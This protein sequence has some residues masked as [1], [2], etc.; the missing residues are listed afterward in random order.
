M[1]TPTRPQRLYLLG[2]LGGD[3][4]PSSASG[5]SR[6]KVSCLRR[7]FLRPPVRGL[8]AEASGSPVVT[9]LGR[10]AVGKT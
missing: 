2:L 3:S 7:G 8:D 6:I 1:P 5:I 9:E 10:Q 4:F